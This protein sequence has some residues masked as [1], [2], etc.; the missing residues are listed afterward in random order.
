[1]S[2]QTDISAFTKI[3]AGWN[4]HVQCGRKEGLP[5]PCRNPA[6]WRFASHC[7]HRGVVCTRHKNLF[8]THNRAIIGRDGDVNCYNCFARFT[9]TSKI[10]RFWRL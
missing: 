4:Q 5:H 8:I 10:A 7:G 1:M 6:S 9:D 2:T 3:I